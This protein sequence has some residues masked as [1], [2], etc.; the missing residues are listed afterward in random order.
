MRGIEVGIDDLLQRRADDRL[1]LIPLRDDNAFEA[2]A[3]LPPDADRRVELS[4]RLD[5]S[6]I[7]IDVSDSGPGVD[8]ALGMAIF[9]EGVSSKSTNGRPR[10]LGLSLVRHAVLRRGGVIDV[11]NDGGAV[12]RVRLPAAATLKVAAAAS[13]QQ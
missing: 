11:V 1:R 7:A 5:E 10:G 13:A 4:I 3:Q 6:G 12:F 2:V 8:P 9:D